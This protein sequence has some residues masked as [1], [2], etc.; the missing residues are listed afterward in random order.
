MNYDQIYVFIQAGGSFVHRVA[1]AVAVAAANIL[2]E[3][4]ATAQ[5]SLR[6]TWASKALGDPERMAKI[7]MYGVMSNVSLQQSGNAAPDSDIQF[8]VNSLIN[9]YLNVV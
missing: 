6:V 8:V 4:P 5:H 3:D 7:M 1:V 9:S 2:S